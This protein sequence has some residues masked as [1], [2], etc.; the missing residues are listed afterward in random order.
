LAAFG[1]N[2]TRW[3]I[4]LPSAAQQAQL[5][6][7]TKGQAQQKA[8]RAFLNRL[9]ASEEQILKAPLVKKKFTHLFAKRNRSMAQRPTTAVASKITLALKWLAAALALMAVSTGFL[10]WLNPSAFPFLKLPTSETKESPTAQMASNSAQGKTTDGKKTSKANEAKT[11]DVVKAD[12]AKAKNTTR[13]GTD[14]VDE[15]PTEA[16][17]GQAWA[18]TLPKDSYLVQHMALPVFKNVAAWQRAN[19]KLTEAHI[20]A[21]Y[22]PGDKLAQFALV[23]GPFKSRSAAVEFTQQAQTPRLAFA[24]SSTRLAERLMPSEAPPAVKPKEPRR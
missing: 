22:K 11:A 9:N 4:D 8:V 7:Q 2:I 21:T 10:Y 3:E 6:A 12:T 14:L 15:L 5:I 18:K 1:K 19:P 23:S 17:A 20:V 16:A 13:A 24:L